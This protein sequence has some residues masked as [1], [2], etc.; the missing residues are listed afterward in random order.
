MSKTD[1]VYA[2]PR[3]QVDAFTFNDQVADVF[4]NMISR[5][6]PGYQL[7]LDMIGI[8]TDRYAQAGSRCYD[9]GCSLGAST[10]KIRH[11]LPADCH[12]VAVDNS[13]AMVKRCQGN[14]ERDHSAAT[15]EVRLADLRK[16]NIEDASVV[17]MNFTLQFVADED[18][19]ALLKRI[20]DGLRPGGILILAE[21]I[22]YEN[23][24]V[25]DL[26]TDLHHD[27]KRTNGYSDLE[28]AQKRTALEN[29]LVPNTDDE[30]LKRLQDAGFSSVTQ[31][32]RC[33]NFASY[34][35]IK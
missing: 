4:D 1:Q 25:Q 16:V 2:T 13:E 18:R 32:I 23:E 12:I 35:A 7:M 6:V 15:V 11:H 8:L 19:P 34:L 5:S 22:R 27:F 20:C 3:E 31:C 9:L 17:V 24:T 21:K 26:L 14:L 30:H 10:L 33:L 29:V 28:I